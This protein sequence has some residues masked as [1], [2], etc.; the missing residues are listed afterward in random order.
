[1][2]EA[3]DQLEDSELLNRIRQEWHYM[4]VCDGFPNCLFCRREAPHLSRKGKA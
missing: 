3:A 2:G 4:G 1:M